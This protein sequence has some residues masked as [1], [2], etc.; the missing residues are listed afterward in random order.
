M[1]GL[2]A[3]STRQALLK[4]HRHAATRALSTPAQAPAP[5]ILPDFS[6]SGKVGLPC[7][8]CAGTWDLYELVLTLGRTVDRC[9]SW[10]RIRVRQRVRSF[11]RVPDHVQVPERASSR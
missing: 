8:L 2:V 4:T 3:R 9:C 6:M 11:V 10:S 1:S 5:R 7:H